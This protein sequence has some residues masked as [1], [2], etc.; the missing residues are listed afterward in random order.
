MKKKFSTH[1]ISSKQPRKQRKY[2]ANAP[3]HL[4]KK[5]VSVGLS[6]PL[7]EKHGKRNLPVRKGDTVKIMVGKFRKKQG[8]VLEV[9]TKTGKIYVEGVQGKK[10]DASKVNI[11]LQSSN[12]Q[13]VELNLDDKK[14]IKTHK[15]NQQNA[16]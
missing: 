13:I 16:H 3:L 2:R 12:L 9:K 6:K 7:R 15:E 4:K 5:F 1:W 10:A 14:R 8:K 11:P